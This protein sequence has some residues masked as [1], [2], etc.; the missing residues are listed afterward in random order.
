MLKFVV[1]AND[2][3]RDKALKRRKRTTLFS[4]HIDKCV[5]YSGLHVSKFLVCIEIISICSRKISI[6]EKNFLCIA[7]GTISHFISN[8]FGCRKNNPSSPVPFDHILIWC[9]TPFKRSNC[10]LFQSP[11]FQ[12]IRWKL[13]FDDTISY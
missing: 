5:L 3:N 4:G 1:L 13:D 11:C 6:P 2:S 10:L 7:L 9:L 12:S 8:Y